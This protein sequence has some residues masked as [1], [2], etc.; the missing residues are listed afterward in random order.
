MSGAHRTMMTSRCTKVSTK[1]NTFRETALVIGLL[2]DNGEWIAAMHDVSSYASSKKVR[3]TFA[4][5]LFYCQPSEPKDPF[6][7]FLDQLSDDF[8]HKEANAQ[9]CPR[10]D[11]DMDL[12]K[13]QVL[14]AI[15]DELSQMGGSLSNYNDMPQPKQNST[16]FNKEEQRKMYS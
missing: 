2:E 11:V 4:I 12:I 10:E 6:E 1:Y 5:I 8:V 15:E 14:L 9:R 3:E 16:K 7:R 13:D